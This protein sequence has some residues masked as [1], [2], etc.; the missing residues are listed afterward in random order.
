MSYWIKK[1]LLFFE[2]QN[3]HV[4]IVRCMHVCVCVCVCLH[5]ALNAHI[6]IIIFFYMAV[7]HHKAVFRR[8]AQLPVL[9]LFHR[10][11]LYSNDKY[12]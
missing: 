12:S 6:D 1:D 2:N 8:K 11:Y 9:V 10:F 5:M 7:S 3:L 4:F